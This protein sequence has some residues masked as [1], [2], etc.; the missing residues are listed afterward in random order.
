MKQIALVIFILFLHCVESICQVDSLSL[1]QTISE[2]ME[3]N[4]TVRIARLDKEIA[5]I[6]N[7][8][9]MAGQSPSVAAGVADQYST[10][11]IYQ[12]FSTGQEIRSSDAAGNNL[13]AFIAL[14][15]TI[16]SGFRISI[17]RDR[18]EMM[19]G[20][21]E[22]QLKNQMAQTVRDVT[23]SYMALLRISKQYMQA[24]EIAGLNEERSILAKASFDAGVAGKSLWLQAEVDKNAQL[25]LLRSLE[26]Q[27]TQLRQAINLLMG[28]DQNSTWAVSHRSQLKVLEDEMKMRG[29][30]LSSN[31][32]LKIAAQ[33]VELSELVVKSISG[34]QL[35]TV[36]ASGAYNFSR[37]DNS[38]G[39]S[40]LNR[41]YGPVAGVNI[42][43]PL[44]TG[45]TIRTRKE[46]AVLG[47]E[48]SNLQ[49]DEIEL[50]LLTGFDSQFTVYKGFYNMYA[51]QQQTVEMARE[52]F[53][54]AS[55]RFRLGQAGIL[56]VREAEL[57]YQNAQT[58]LNELEYEI[59]IAETELLLLSGK[60]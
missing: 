59:K 40:L 45:G 39:F 20:L 18:L 3:K 16:F 1:E 19:E 27:M 55:D 29:E 31:L 14:D 12:R 10:N 41:N 54:I 52:N 13:T 21:G 6:S 58:Q 9:G 32:E 34:E 50:R 46:L 7:T 44:F 51:L 2:A 8:R 38:A 60:L 47:V 25:Q 26:I 24:K 43:I 28:R 48:R 5:E 22:I 23:V 4:Y 49:M 30:V 37:T 36:V 57:S 33:S 35:P 56:E 17:E 11:N 53:Q 15:W 42:G